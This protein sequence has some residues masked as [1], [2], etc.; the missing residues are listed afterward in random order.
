MSKPAVIEVTAA[1]SNFAQ[2]GPQARQAP[3]QVT[4]HGKVEFVVISPEL[5]AALEASGAAPANEL[6]RMQAS[7]E[8]MVQGM[9]SEQSAAAYDAVAN[10]PAEDLAGAVAR[11]QHKLD[12]AGA[13]ARRPKLR[14]AR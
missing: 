9:Q 7:F 5:F 4:R 12:R 3:V 14:V 11:A 2:L 1:R 13:A 8:A 10:L 6:E